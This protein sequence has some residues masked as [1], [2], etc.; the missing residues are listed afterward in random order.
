MGAANS[1]IKISNITIVP[2]DVNAAKELD[3]LVSM[4]CPGNYFVF[5]YFFKLFVL[6]IS[7]EL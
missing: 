3:R 4:E 7:I 2:Q 6:K 1:I 5:K